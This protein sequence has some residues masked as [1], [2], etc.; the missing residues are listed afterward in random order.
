MVLAPVSAFSYSKEDRLLDAG[1]Y[2]QVF[3]QVDAKVSHKNLLLLATKNNLKHDRLGLIIAK[4]HVRLAV[5]R[6]RIKRVIREVFRNH[7][8]QSP[9]LD[10]IVLAR[11]GADQLDNA[12]LSSILRLQW[13]KLATQ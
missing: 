5:Q 12:S 7:P 3:D 6:N 10:I 2:R 4:K 11:K 9:G 1:A 8:S 13:Q